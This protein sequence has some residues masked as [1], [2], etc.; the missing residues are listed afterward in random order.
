MDGQEQ[1]FRHSATC[2]FRHVTHRGRLKQLLVGRPYVPYTPEMVIAKRDFERV[3]IF[4]LENFHVARSGA[5]ITSLAT[6]IIAVYASN[7][8][9][10]SHVTMQEACARNT[11]TYTRY[12][13]GFGSGNFGLVTGVLLTLLP[14]T[15]VVLFWRTWRKVLRRKPVYGWCAHA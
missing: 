12:L 15:S 7:S 4:A 11:R 5:A 3:N 1:P 8:R 6:A 2:R 14:L 10:A 9:D 13:L